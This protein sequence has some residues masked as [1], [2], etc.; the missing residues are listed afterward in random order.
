MRQCEAVAMKPA[1]AAPLFPAA[2]GLFPAAAAEEVAP[3]QQLDWL[4]NESAAPEKCYDSAV[5]TTAAAAVPVPDPAPVTRPKPATASS[6][7][8]R[9][10]AADFVPRCA[11]F[12]PTVKTGYTA[13]VR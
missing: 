11:V 13:A 8:R 12:V 2:S 5:P 3:P 7:K 4:R 9:P 1:Q 10:T 6:G